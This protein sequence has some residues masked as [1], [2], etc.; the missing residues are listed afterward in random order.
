MPVVT[1]TRIAHCTVLVDF[2]GAKILTDPWFSERFGYDHGEPYG[3]ALGNLPRL[4][5]VVVSHGHYDHCDMNAFGAYPD[6]QVAIAV[7]RGIAKTALK[8]GFTNVTEM[9]AWETTK[10]GPVT[11][12]AAPGK[13]GVPEIT[14]VLQAASQP[15]TSAETPCLFLN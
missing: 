1:V 11:V 3:I 6:K 5:G 2:D 9:D 14:Y 7:K 13:H 15:F 10:L 12:T 4:A 8:A